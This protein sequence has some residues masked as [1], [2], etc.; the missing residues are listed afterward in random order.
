MSRPRQVLV[1]LSGIGIAIGIYE[2]VEFN[3]TSPSDWI[4]ISLVA[5]CALVFN[6]LLALELREKRS[7]RTELGIAAQV[8]RGLFPA[9]FPQGDFFRFS[10]HHTPAL[11]V[12]GDYYDVFPLG[13]GRIAMIVADV[14]GKG[15]AAAIMMA[16]VRARFRSL[17]HVGIAPGNLL[18]RVGNM[19][20]PETNAD[21]FVT[22][23]FGIFDPRAE[24]FRYSNGG[25]EP[26]YLIGPEPG[27]TRLDQ[28]GLPLGMFPDTRYE[29]GVVTL[30][31]GSAVLI[32]TDGITEATN[33]SGQFFDQERLERSIEGCTDRDPDRMV[34]AIIS[35]VNEFRAG[36]EQNDDITLL[37]LGTTA[38]EVSG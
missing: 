4:N 30:A 19:L 35:S 10:G 12:G 3:R 37:V 17:G 14:S 16:T 9:D 21:Q 11:D 2:L 18:G 27:F 20:I 6:G 1:T 8:Q 23:F 22:L 13:D 29:E 25:H 36:A 28:G 24:T 31:P 7:Y 32:Y 33:N 38:G 34:D 15:A 26:P 5:M